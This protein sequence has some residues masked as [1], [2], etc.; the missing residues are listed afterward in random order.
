MG[1]FNIVMNNRAKLGSKRIDRNAV[2]DFIVWI[3]DIDVA[4]IPSR[5]FEHTWSNNRD[6]DQRVYTK[7]DHMFCNEAWQNLIK[8][9]Q[10]DY[11]APISSDHSPD[12]LSVQ[13]TNKSGT[14]PF[15]F[16]KGWMS[17]P[18]FKHTLETGWS[19]VVHGNPMVRLS[20]K[21]KN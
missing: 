11:G 2:K 12:I 5:G 17:H 10:L 8:D 13:L 1:D 20:K 7:I 6:E 15:K 3:N 4:Y 18:K 21:L 19:D 16:M 9:F 14:H